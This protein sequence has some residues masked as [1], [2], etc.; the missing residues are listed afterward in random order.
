MLAG[1]A[2]ATNFGTKQAPYGDNSAPDEVASASN[3]TDD[4]GSGIYPLTSAQTRIYLAQGAS[5]ESSTFSDGFAIS[6]S[7]EIPKESLHGALKTIMRR[8]AILHVEV[9]QSG[10]SPALQKVLPFNDTLFGSVFVHE[11]LDHTSITIC[12]HEIFSRPFK[13][14]GVDNLLDS[15]RLIRTTLLS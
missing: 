15:Q 12:T 13:V 1:D 6:I 7:G 11:H 10:S 9:F 2:G 5:P 8:H 14:F 3:I 4:P